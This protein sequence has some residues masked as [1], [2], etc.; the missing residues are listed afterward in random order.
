[1]ALDAPL[2]LD[3]QLAEAMKTIPECLAGAYDDMQSGMLLSVKTLDSHPQDVLDMVAAATA[4]M[5]QGPTVT[6]IERHFAKSRGQETV[7]HYF[8]EFIV[9]SKNLIHIYLRTKQYPDHVV[10]YVCRNSANIGMVLAK[11]RM[12][13]AKLSA[14][15]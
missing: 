3:A 8:H 13:V 10:C 2:S 15:V 9:Y 11:S 4:D 14:A 5:F 6:E 1:M 7:E 12:T